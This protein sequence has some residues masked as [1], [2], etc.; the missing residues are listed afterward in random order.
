MKKR[1]IFLVSLLPALLTAAAIATAVIAVRRAL[2]PPHSPGLDESQTRV[3]AHGG[4]ATG[5]PAIEVETQEFDMGAI[6]NSETTTKRMKVHN[7][8]TGDLVVSGMK[9]SCGCA[10]GAMAQR[11][12]APGDGA[13]MLITV[14]P[15]KVG[16]AFESRKVLT[17]M[18]NA[19]NEPE[20]KVTVTARILPEIAMEPSSIDFGEV[21]KGV[22][23]EASM[24]V[25][26]LDERPLVIEALNTKPQPDDGILV[27][28]TEI[29]PEEWMTSGHREY[30]ITAAVLPQ[31]SVGE[32]EVRFTFKTG[33]K[34]LGFVP[35]VVKA[36]L[37]ASYRIEQRPEALGFINP[38]EERKG[39]VLI[40]SDRPIEVAGIATPTEI[41]VT[42]RP[43]D[44]PNSILLDIVADENL[45]RGAKRWKV[46]LGIK[47]D[48]QVYKETIVIHD[49]LRLETCAPPKRAREKNSPGQVRSLP[50]SE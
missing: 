8:G 46:F 36:Q 7:R 27:S 32:H 17:I 11:V 29:P 18:S 33:Y 20:L 41:L 16:G 35:G 42:S 25:R 12:I 1:S 49:D 23:R 2:P 37:T 9:T 26:Q 6:S 19:V 10:K 40:T 38:G 22:R 3:P 39:F 5:E 45:S 15:F 47:S 30:R 21:P 34:R 44:E 14:D 13:D 43:G 50:N 24:L 4:S 48:G 31:A 28:C